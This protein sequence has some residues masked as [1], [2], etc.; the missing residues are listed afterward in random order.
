MTLIQCELTT[1]TPTTEAQARA[2]LTEAQF[3][4]IKRRAQDQIKRKQAENAAVVQPSKTTSTM[5]TKR[6]EKNKENEADA[7]D[8]FDFRKL[9]RRAP[10]PGATKALAPKPPRTALDYF[11][12]HLFVLKEQ[13][14]DAADAVLETM[15]AAL[16]ADERRQFVAKAARD[17]KRFATAHA[18]WLAEQEQEQ[19]Q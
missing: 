7:D 15:F 13:S 8:E 17:A 14:A 11:R 3:E 1:T 2:M 6:D 5:K 10:L 19:E 4:D 9:V 18:K 12:A 16:A